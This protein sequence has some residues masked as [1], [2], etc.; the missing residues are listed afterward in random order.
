MRVIQP[1][2]LHVAA[3]VRY[4]LPYLIQNMSVKNEYLL[5]LL[6]CMRDFAFHA[7]TNISAAYKQRITQFQQT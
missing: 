2:A 1:H 6:R 7:V 4:D 5:S 3:G